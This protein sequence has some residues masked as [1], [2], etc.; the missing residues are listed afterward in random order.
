MIQCKINNVNDILIRFIFFDGEIPT[1]ENS[2]CCAIDKDLLT[3]VKTIQL[4][5]NLCLQKL[6]EKEKKNG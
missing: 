1:D 3:D 2:V 5:T 6:Q 4:T